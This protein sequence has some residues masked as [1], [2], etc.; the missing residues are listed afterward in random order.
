MALTS[1][2]D[3]E[4]LT[5]LAHPDYLAFISLDTDRFL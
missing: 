5:R 3:L 1:L 4:K 2:L